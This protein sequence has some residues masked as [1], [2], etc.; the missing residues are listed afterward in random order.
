MSQQALSVLHQELRKCFRSLEAN[1]TVWRSVLVDCTPL[2]SSLGNLAEQLRALKNV[3]VSTT[4]LA[5]FPDLKERLQHKLVQAVD[6][7][8]GQLMEKMCALQLV[9]ESTSKQVFAV[10]QQYE[11]SADSLDIHS[12]TARSAVSPSTADMLEWLQDAERYYRVQYIQRKNLLQMLK[13]EQ[14]MLMETAPKTW[15]A[16][17]SPGGEDNITDVLHQVSFFMESE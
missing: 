1:Q 9:R 2:M 15:A 14:L 11:R 16:L 5:Q 12:C 13:P 17:Q 7:V 6:T 10:V 3:E 4:P 8:L